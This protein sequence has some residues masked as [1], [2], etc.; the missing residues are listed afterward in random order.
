MV[1]TYLSLLASRRFI[2]LQYTSEGSSRLSDAGR[3]YAAKTKRA[4]LFSFAVPHDQPAPSH[5]LASAT[6][7]LR[8]IPSC[9]RRRARSRRT[10]AETTST[11]GAW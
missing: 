7:L 8:L 3:H 9:S 2:P 1:A 4:K 6:A 10:S 11:V 5:N